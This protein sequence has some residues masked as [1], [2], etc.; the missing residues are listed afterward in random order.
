[1]AGVQDKQAYLA[2]FA[3]KMLGAVGLFSITAALALSDLGVGTLNQRRAFWSGL[4]VVCGVLILAGAAA[5]R[6]V[7]M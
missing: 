4:N 2:A 3:I 5:M 6:S 7:R 1:L